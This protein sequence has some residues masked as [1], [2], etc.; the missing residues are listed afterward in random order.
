MK[1]SVYSK[2]TD[3][4]LRNITCPPSEVDKQ[5]KVDVEY[6]KEGHGEFVVLV[7]AER[8]ARKL[9]NYLLQQSDWTQMP[10]APEANKAAWATYR[11]ELR[12]V[13][14]QVGFPDNIIWPEVP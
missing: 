4:L 3:E 14:N 2:D 5:I 8:E 7:D 9:R 10:D 11:Q 6:Y 12:D 13:T 1:Y